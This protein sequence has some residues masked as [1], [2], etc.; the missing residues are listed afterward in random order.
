MDYN[1]FSL[2]PRHI[3]VPLIAPKMI[4]EHMVR[5]AQTMH[6]SCVEINTISKQ[7]EM[8]FHL[9]YAT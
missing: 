9:I 5:S 1:E 6:L 8:I 2:D 7:T 3:G 4:F